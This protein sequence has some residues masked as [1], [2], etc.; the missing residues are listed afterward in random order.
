MKI[1]H[2]VDNDALIDELD[3]LA[4][5]VSESTFR[6]CDAMADVIQPALVRAAPF[7]RKNVKYEHL[8]KVIAKT[9]PRKKDG[10]AQVVVWVNRRGVTPPAGTSKEKRKSYTDKHIYKIVVSEY[11]R[12][13]LP[14]RPFWTPTVV[15]KAETALRAGTAIL[16]EALEK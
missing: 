14:A 11:G 2:F 15:Q 1:T 16:K 5:R 13:N 4:V 6:A 7:D 8:K 12:S 3:Q 9:K 10:N